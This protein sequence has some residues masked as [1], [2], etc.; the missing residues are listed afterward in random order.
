MSTHDN[1]LDALFRSKLDGFEAEPSAG[2]W[3]NIS[4][5]LHGA[6]D[7][8]KRLMPLLRI[9]ASVAILIA[10]GLLFIPRNKKVNHTQPANRLVKNTIIKP[11]VITKPTTIQQPVNI[12]TP[13]KQIIGVKYQQQIAAAHQTKAHQVIVTA[14]QKQ[15]VAA[16]DQTDALAAANSQQALMAA[17]QTKVN[18]TKPVVP[19]SQVSLKAVDVETDTKAASTLAAVNPAMADDAKPAPVKKR[20]ARGFG[21]ILN[22][23][24]GVVDKRQD[25]II[26]FTDTDEGDTITGINLGIVKIKKQK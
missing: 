15:A 4:Q 20:K 13:V 17:V 14:I 21:G 6:G 11:S 3:A 7:R 23:M 10:A 12:V 25:K 24:I 19:D 2:V 18:V 16:P 22:A 5:E 1:D 9:A 26:E 8:R